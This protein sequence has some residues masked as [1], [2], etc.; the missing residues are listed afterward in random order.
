MMSKRLGDLE[1][2]RESFVRHER[3][4]TEERDEILKNIRA[5]LDQLDVEIVRLGGRARD[6]AATTG[7]RGLAPFT[8]V[9][10]S[11]DLEEERTENIS[12]KKRGRPS[13]EKVP[14]HVLVDKVLSHVLVPEK[15]NATSNDASV[16]DRPKKR[17]RQSKNVLSSSK[18]STKGETVGEPWTCECGEHMAAGRKRCGKCRR[19]KGGRRDIRWSRKS[20]GAARASF[21]TAGGVVRKAMKAHDVYRNLPAA[22]FRAAAAVT[23]GKGPRSEIQSIVEVMV[24]CVSAAARARPHSGS[25]IQRVVSTSDS[26]GGSTAEPQRKRVCPEKIDDIKGKKRL[27]QSAPN[28]TGQTVIELDLETEGTRITAENC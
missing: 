13:K 7:D 20:T 24:S 17:P 2:E 19:W 12:K 15:V 23:A 25:S 10:E 1:A 16:D 28:V 21:E 22:P 14:S 11:P 26:D 8:S 3:R 4:I 5:H 6:A 18:S 27:V 9:K